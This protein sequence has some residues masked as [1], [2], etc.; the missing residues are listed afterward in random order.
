MVYNIRVKLRI[1]FGIVAKGMALGGLRCSA[2][3][4]KA[5]IP[6]APEA[7]PALPFRLDLTI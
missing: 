7:L 6:H 5:P 1:G 3:V 4:R 2:V